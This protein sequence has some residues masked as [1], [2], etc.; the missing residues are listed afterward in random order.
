M[1]EKK[2]LLNGS[3]LSKRSKTPSKKTSH[4]LEKL[5]AATFDALQKH[6]DRKINALMK[7]DFVFHMTDWEEDLRRLQNLMDNPERLSKKEASEV[8]AGFLYHATSHIKAAASL[9]LDFDPI[10]FADPRT[11]ERGSVAKK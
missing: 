1:S 11:S 6:E 10:E 3:P 4:K 5:L 8:V 9:L 7:K 2:L